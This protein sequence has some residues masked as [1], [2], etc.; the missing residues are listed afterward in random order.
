MSKKVSKSNKTEELKKKALSFQ[1]EPIVSGIQAFKKGDVILTWGYIDTE[2]WSKCINKSRK[3]R[4]YFNF[5]LIPLKETRNGQT[6]IAVATKQKA[7][8]E[9]GELVFAGKKRADEAFLNNL[10]EKAEVAA[11]AQEELKGEVK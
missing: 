10:S 4:L 5:K 9:N 1:S 11:L 6:H 7:F 2:D 8:I 3:G